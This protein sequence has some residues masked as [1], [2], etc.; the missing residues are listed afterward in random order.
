MLSASG[1][2]CTCITKENEH[3]GGL[4]NILYI[5]LHENIYDQI[6]FNVSFSSW[7]TSLCMIKP[8]SCLNVKG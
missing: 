3:L 1:L 2:P 4:V 8:G 6:V 7:P 5:F